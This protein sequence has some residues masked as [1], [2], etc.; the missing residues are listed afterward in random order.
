MHHVV[1]GV[2]EPFLSKHEKRYVNES[3]QNF[4][5]NP[6]VVFGGL[7][8]FDIMLITDEADIEDERATVYEGINSDSEEDF[9]ATYETGD[10]DEDGDVGVEA[11]T[12]NVMVHS[13]NSQP[14]NVS[15]FMH[16]LDLD[17]MHAPKFS[18]YAN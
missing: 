14:I 7:I 13:S 18:E 15:P 4:V 8:Q 2:S 10:E 12:K 5:P 3:E 16:D 11:A 17:S 6:V 9:E 1:S